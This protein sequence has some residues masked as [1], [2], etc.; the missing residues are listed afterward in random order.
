LETWTDVFGFV[1]RSQ[2]AALVP[3]FD[4]LALER[5]AN[6]LAFLKNRKR[7][8]SRRKKWSTILDRQFVSAVQFYLH[9]YG[10]VTLGKLLITKST[11]LSEKGKIHLR[12]LFYV[13]NYIFDYLLSSLSSYPDYPFGRDL[14]LADVPMSTNI[15]EFRGIR[16]R[17]D[18][19]IY[20]FGLIHS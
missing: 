13:I 20:K 6:I 12:F 2:L 4:K 18:F 14:P 7:K 11:K 1:P 17:F 3:N 16:L 10:R 8:R 19:K 5:D 9:K 15:K